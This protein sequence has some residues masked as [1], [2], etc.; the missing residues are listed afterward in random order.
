MPARTLVELRTH[1]TRSGNGPLDAEPILTSWCHRLAAF[2]TPA[3]IR[4]WLAV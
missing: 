2:A 3:A 1:Q 4:P